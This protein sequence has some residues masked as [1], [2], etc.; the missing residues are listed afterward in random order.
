MD[1]NK[2]LYTVVVVCFQVEQDMDLGGDTED[3]EPL[4]TDA[5]HFSSNQVKDILEQITSRNNLSERIQR[6]QKP[7]TDDFVPP[8]DSAFKCPLLDIDQEFACGPSSLSS[9]AQ[10]SQ[11]GTVVSLLSGHPFHQRKVA[12]EEGWPLKRGTFQCIFYSSGRKKW[13]LTR[14]ASQEE[15]HC[16]RNA[17]NSP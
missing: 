13:P 3:E 7:S 10:Y 17:S 14:G 6:L 5:F 15:D 1:L 8:D 9:A 12:C 2:V 4:E 11:V 16:I